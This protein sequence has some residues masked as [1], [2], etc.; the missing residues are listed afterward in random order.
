MAANTAEQAVGQDDED[1]DGHRA[2]AERD[3]AGLDRVGAELGAHGAL[4]LDLQLAPAGAGP[5]QQGQ[6]AGA[7]Q[8]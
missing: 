1:D 7:L 6:V 2:D 3:G 5:Q 4:L 8:A